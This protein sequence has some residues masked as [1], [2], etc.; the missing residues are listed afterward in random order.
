M[1][2]I[3]VCFYANSD[4]ESYERGWKSDLWFEDGMGNKI[5]MPN[6]ILN[7]F[8]SVIGYSLTPSQFG[9][10]P[11]GHSD[12]IGEVLE[13][14]GW[15]FIREDYNSGNDAYYVYYEK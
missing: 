1:S 2:Q 15:K 8:Q 14:S 4:C 10:D 5:T 12:E 13:D 11:A 9:T 3:V 6:F 7:N